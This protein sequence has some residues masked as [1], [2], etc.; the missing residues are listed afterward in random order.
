M[1]FLLDHD[2][3][4]E[5]SRVLQHW[6]HNVTALRTVLPVTA[7]DADVFGY[8]CLE[9]LI[10]ISCNRDHFLALAGQTHNHP[11]LIILIRRKTR[12]AEC[13]HRSTNPNHLA[14]SQAECGKEQAKRENQ[15][16]EKP[17][18]RRNHREPVDH[19]R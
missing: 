11:G 1:K 15:R 16:T 14:T 13:A 3:P 2:V 4:A 12:Q 10:I 7:P 6:G 19:P 9:G 17:Q 8:A 18:H 5:I